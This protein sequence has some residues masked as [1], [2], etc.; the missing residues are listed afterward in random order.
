MS[1]TY[2]L[3]RGSEG[4]ESLRIWSLLQIRLDEQSE[5]VAR[6]LSAM[7]AFS[8]PDRRVLISLRSHDYYS[9]ALCYIPLPLVASMGSIYASFVIFESLSLCLFFALQS[10]SMVHTR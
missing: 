8:A 3:Y 7:S 10:Y 6:A 1:R 9:S 4:S 2:Y 5:C